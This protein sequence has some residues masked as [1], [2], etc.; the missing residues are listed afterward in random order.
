MLYLTF[1]AATSKEITIFAFLKFDVINFCDAARSTT[2]FDRFVLFA[3]IVSI[4]S[5]WM[6]IVLWLPVT[7]AISMATQRNPST[8]PHNSTRCE[9][10]G[11]RWG[12][13]L[14]SSLEVDLKDEG[15]ANK[16]VLLDWLLRKRSRRGNK[17]V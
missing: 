4:Y 16:V 9:R 5:I 15:W 1:V 17:E 3:H 13:G 7:E 10:R 8:T 12:L 11:V 6:F 2:R 14:S